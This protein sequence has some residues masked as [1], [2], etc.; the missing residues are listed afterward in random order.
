VDAVIG[1]RRRRFVAGLLAAAGLGGCAWGGQAAPAGQAALNYR[2][3]AAR[4]LYEHHFDQVHDGKLPPVLHAVAAIRT[5]VDGNGRVTRIQ[6]TR[7]PADAPEVPAW[8]ER[9]IR[10]AEPLPKPPAGRRIEYQEI[11]LVTYQ[12]RFQLH[13]LSEGQADQDDDTP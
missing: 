9:M 12:G 8:I 3:A 7:Q 1:A 4:H 11:W 5:T 13:T 6:V 10:A 2:I